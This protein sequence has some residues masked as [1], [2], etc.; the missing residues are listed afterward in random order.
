MS[1]EIVNTRGQTG[2]TIGW[3]TVEKNGTVVVGSLVNGPNHAGFAIRR[4]IMPNGKARL[5]V[6]PAKHISGVKGER[7]LAPGD[8]P[9][10]WSDKHNMAVKAELLKR[11]PYLNGNNNPWPNSVIKT[12]WKDQKDLD[13]IKRREAA[14][15]KDDS[16]ELVSE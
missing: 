15:G 13:H 3:L 1:T 6:H 7:V 8:M 4:S 2:M 12:S 11:A 14:A 9:V 16:I 5:G 10:W